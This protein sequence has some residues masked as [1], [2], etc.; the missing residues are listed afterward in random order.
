M[1]VCAERRG[2]LGAKDGVRIERWVCPV[3][4]GRKRRQLGARALDRRACR[5]TGD[6][7]ATNRVDRRD[8]IALGRLRT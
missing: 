2:G 5:E 6:D 7:L 3:D 4:R 1:H 8:T